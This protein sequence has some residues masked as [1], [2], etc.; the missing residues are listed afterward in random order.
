MS[1][2]TENVA[3]KA[4]ATDVSNTASDQMSTEQ[5]APEGVD[6]ALGWFEE[7]RT[8]PIDELDAES[9]AVR[10]RCDWILM[11]II[12]ITYALQFLDN[13][14]LGYAYAYGVLEDTGMTPGDYNWLASIYYFGY[15]FWA[16]P[17][18]LLLQK[19]PV[20]TYTTV[21][22]FLWGVL[23]FMCCV[24][25]SF[26]GFAVLRFLL[27]CLEVG[28]TPTM[29]V[30]TS[31]FYKREETPVRNSF[32][33][34]SFG[35]GVVVLSIVSYGLGNSHSSISNWKLVFLFVGAITTAWAAV[36]Y[37]FVP[38]TP[39]ETRWLT[40]RQKLVVIHR[41]STNKIGIKDKK[42][43]PYQIREA[44]RDP[45]LWLL[46]AFQITNGIC[47]SS[48]SAFASPLIEGFG[49]D[50]LQTVLLQMPTGA[51]V[52]V[53]EPILGYIA[54][55]TTNTI[56]WISIAA[57]IPNVAGL[58]GIRFISRTENHKWALLGCTW[59]QFIFGVTNLFS[60]TL[61]ASNFA[62]HS[63][64]SFVNAA[65][66]A[67]FGVGNLI[68][69]HIFFPSEAPVYESAIT[70][71]LVCFGLSISFNLGLRTYMWNENRR[72]DGAFARGEIQNVDGELE[73]F[74]DKTDM[75]NKAFRYVL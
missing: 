66:F 65:I 28:I 64:R 57:N 22:I 48:V 54:T 19:L 39:T 21:L 53:I 11:P 58:F 55:K 44:L 43:K 16:Y 3:A 10:R 9:T 17:S 40:H 20:A 26:A 13:A 49:F 50:A 12:C 70:G 56:I 74:Y 15:L 23:T 73:G 7:M 32:W 60:W 38:N 75:E 33:Q 71:L 61:T 31:S 51:F 18:T 67:C 45:K 36:F 52:A 68:G 37:Y 14:V 42:I 4:A 69:P 25:N 63:K 35:S 1:E 59:L 47:N 41:I 72:R 5:V 29:M 24:A 62:G 2:K 34:S 30:I 27:G 6:I 46:C 8:I